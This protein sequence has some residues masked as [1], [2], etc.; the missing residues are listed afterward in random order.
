MEVKRKQRAAV[1]LQSKFRARQAWVQMQRLKRAAV[2]L[3]SKVRA[4]QAL[5]QLQ[6]LKQAERERT[7]SAEVE[8]NAK[9][10]ADM[11]YEKPDQAPTGFA[12]KQVPRPS[13]GDMVSS[14]GR[15][16]KTR[17]GQ[18]VRVRNGGNC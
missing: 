6:K 5:I 1:R 16:G 4:R 17:T 12:A 15:D 13:L 11:K 14:V 3:Q 9:E 18:I 8:R 10:R 7:T 2:K